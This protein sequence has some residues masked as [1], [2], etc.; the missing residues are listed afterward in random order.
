MAAGGEPE[1][2]EIQLRDG[3]KQVQARLRCYILSDKVYRPGPDGN[4]LLSAYFAYHIDCSLF[5]QNINDSRILDVLDPEVRDGI[6]G[7]LGQK[8]SC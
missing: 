5:L 1:R 6:L 3:G 4:R 8:H 7:S 2:T